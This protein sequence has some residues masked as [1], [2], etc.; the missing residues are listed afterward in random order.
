M[1]LPH[2]GSRRPSGCVS[3]NIITH[4]ENKERRCS[5]APAL[6]IQTAA[7]TTFTALEL[8]WVA[9]TTDTQTALKERKV[10]AFV[11]SAAP[12]PRD[13]V[14]IPS[15]R[16]VA[17]WLRDRS[18]RWATFAGPRRSFAANSAAAACVICQEASRPTGQPTMTTGKRTKLI[19]QIYL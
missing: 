9:R 8:A 13:P 5:S 3:C 7:E 12:A 19:L 4:L 2:A 18:G 16:I 14:A 6:I 17:A 15:N 11:A 10:C 1:R